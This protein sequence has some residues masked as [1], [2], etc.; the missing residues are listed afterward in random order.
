MVD[1]MDFWFSSF[2]LPVFGLDS[3]GYGETNMARTQTRI[4]AFLETLR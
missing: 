1:E 3:D 4:R 2:G